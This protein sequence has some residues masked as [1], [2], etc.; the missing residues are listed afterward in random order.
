M[1]FARRSLFYRFIRSGFKI[2]DQAQ[3]QGAGRSGKRS[4]A[5]GGMSK[6]IYRRPVLHLNL[7]NQMRIPL[8]G[9]TQPLGLRWGFETTYTA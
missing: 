5:N 6:Y 7:K 1:N 9:A 4:P 8:S 3:G 2:S